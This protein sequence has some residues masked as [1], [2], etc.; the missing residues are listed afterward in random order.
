M[1]CGPSQ[2]KE[3]QSQSRIPSPRKGWEEGSKVTDN[4]RPC[5]STRLDYIVNTGAACIARHCQRE[6]KGGHKRRK[7]A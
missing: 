1:G 3:D 5:G 6:Q 4:H 2:Q 7:D